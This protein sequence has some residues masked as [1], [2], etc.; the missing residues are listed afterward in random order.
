MPRYFFH[1][2]DGVQHIDREGAELRSHAHAHS[3]AVIAAGDMLK[4]VDGHFTNGNWSMRVLDEGGG[5]VSDIMIVVRRR[6][7]A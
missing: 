3:E 5:I 6:K 1:T 2:N 4:D 7:P